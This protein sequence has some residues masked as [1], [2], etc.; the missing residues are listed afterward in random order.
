MS[1]VIEALS[2]VHTGTGVA[3]YEDLASHFVWFS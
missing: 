2:G 3:C 1:L